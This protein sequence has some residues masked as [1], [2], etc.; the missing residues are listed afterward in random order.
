[1]M[2]DPL[3]P[4]DA[5]ALSASLDNRLVD[6]AARDLAKLVHT[7]QKPSAGRFLRSL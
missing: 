3:G 2:Q 4:L 5:A 7:V 6:T 1:M